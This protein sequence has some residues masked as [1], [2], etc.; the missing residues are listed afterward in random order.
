MADLLVRREG[1]ALWL[2][3]DRPAACP[4]PADGAWPGRRLSTVAE[5][6][7]A[8]PRLAREGTDPIGWSA[9]N[10]R[11]N[12]YLDGRAGERLVDWFFA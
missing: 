2:T 5:V 10:G 8:L 6:A 1:A 12:A 9:F 3:L 7:A 4:G 11:H